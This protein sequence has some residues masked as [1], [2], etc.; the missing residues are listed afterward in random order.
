M[1]L[2][3][4]QIKRLDAWLQS[5]LSYS[6]RETSEMSIEQKVSLLSNDGRAWLLES[7]VN[8]EGLK[9]LSI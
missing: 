6:K 9:N 3:A 5:S 1:T 4:F 2:T 7:W 8:L